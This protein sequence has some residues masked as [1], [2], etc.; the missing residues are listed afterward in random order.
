MSGNPMQHRRPRCKK[1]LPNEQS[2]EYLEAVELFRQH[3]LS[4]DQC[5][6]LILAAKGK[7]MSHLRAFAKSMMDKHP[8][9]PKTKRIHD[10]QQNALCAWFSEFWYAMSDDIYMAA[11]TLPENTES[12]MHPERDS[13]SLSE[14]YGR[15]LLDPIV[16]A[17][18]GF[19]DPQY[20]GETIISEPGDFAGSSSYGQTSVTTTSFLD[21]FNSDFGVDAQSLWIE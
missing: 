15:V 16:E 14:A 3:R 4:K 13:A 19:I 11:G 2:A 17:D 9:L 7:K 1:N 8:N 5:N 10:R 12:Q 21:P 6:V 20:I 18:V